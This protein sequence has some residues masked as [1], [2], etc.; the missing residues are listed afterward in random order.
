MSERA[1]ERMSAA[2]RASEASSA[3]RSELVSGASERASG[4]ANGPVLTSRFQ[5]YLNHRAMRNL[6]QKAFVQIRLCIGRLNRAL[7]DGKQVYV[8]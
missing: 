3:E 8:M 1:S 7:S 4:R 5:A 6:M 2:D